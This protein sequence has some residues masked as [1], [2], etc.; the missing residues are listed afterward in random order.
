V[1][2]RG[3]ETTRF[4]ASD[5]GLAT[6]QRFRES[7][8]GA[9]FGDYSVC[10]GLHIAVTITIRDIM[11]HET[12]FEGKGPLGFFEPMSQ[13]Y[14]KRIAVARAE[15]SQTKLGQSI[16]AAQGTVSGWENEERE[17]TLEDLEKIAH[18]T[19]HSVAWI[20]FNLGDPKQFSSN[21]S[22][23]GLNRELLFRVIAGVER[24]LSREGLR[25]SP[26][27]KARLIISVYDIGRSFPS[28]NLLSEELERLLGIAKRTDQK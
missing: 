26:E 10:L 12:P 23:D 5:D 4:P 3:D 24:L 22:T 18:A 16:G 25:K 6:I 15:L 28:E 13:G 19:G 9:E 14:G 20:A 7:G 1:P 11:Q 2:G 21:T 27:E 17:P 8:L